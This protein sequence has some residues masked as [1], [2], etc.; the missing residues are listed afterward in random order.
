MFPTKKKT[1]KRKQP[2]NLFRI[3]QYNYT[4]IE[5]EKVKAVPIRV[6]FLDLCLSIY[7]SLWY[8]NSG[9]FVKLSGY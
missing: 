2:V 6:L 9:F 5:L 3:H 8:Q 1:G 7:N 4:K